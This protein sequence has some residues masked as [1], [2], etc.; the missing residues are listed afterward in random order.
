MTNQTV[1]GRIAHFFIDFIR[2]VCYHVHK[3]GNYNACA[4]PH[5][6]GGGILTGIA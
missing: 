2:F 6:N 1:W 3:M 4:S 5:E